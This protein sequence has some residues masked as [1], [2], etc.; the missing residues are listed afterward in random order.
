MISR[1]LIWSGLLGFAFSVCAAPQ[2]LAVLKVGS[3]TYSN[4]TIMGA[5][6][7]DLYFTHSQGITNVKLK[8]LEE[9]LR[10]RFQYDAQA[11]AEAE[12]QQVQEDAAYQGALASKLVAQVQKAARAAHKAARTSENS[13]ADPIS[14]RSLLGK[15]GPAV[16]AE[17][18]LG[19]K[20][21]LKGKAVLIA[22]WAPWSIPCR[23]AIPELNALQKVL[24]DKLVV[25]G[26][27]SDSQE[28][29]EE[30]AVPKLEFAS[31]I[32]TKGKLSAAAGV[33]SVPYVLLM[34]GKGIV[35]YEGYP[36]AL[37]QK[38]LENLLPNPAE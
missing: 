36:G 15:P 4:V 8:F 7:T 23:K 29:V 31:G 19:E 27:T 1:F 11:A 2:K 18:W 21:V 9:S 30:A 24:A 14:E 26:L 35:R 38:K 34:D 33:T 12:R 20:P 32:D 5:N 3:K 22:F 17:K 6:A 37:D 10:Q 25:V 16:E 13:L 28:E